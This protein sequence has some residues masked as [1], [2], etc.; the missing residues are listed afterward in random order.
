MAS[1]TGL[2]Y[3]TATITL[4]ELDEHFMLCSGISLAVS[5]TA[6]AFLFFASLSSSAAAQ[7]TDRFD[8]FGSPGIRADCEVVA[9]MGDD[10][11]GTSTILSYLEGREMYDGK[12]IELGYDS[13]GV[14][15]WAVIRA[16]ELVATEGDA[17]GRPRTWRVIP[18]AYSISFSRGLSGEGFHVPGLV[19]VQR[20]VLASGRGRALSAE[21][22]GRA[23]RLAESMWIRRCASSAGGD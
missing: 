11:P 14:P 5:P 16:D 20:R 4:P 21:A 17:G 12:L 13:A 7:S 19:K 8:P 1:R 23:R 10:P 18:H 15:L 3:S 2:K 9:P 6:L 22:I